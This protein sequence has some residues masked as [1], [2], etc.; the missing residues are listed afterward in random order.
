MRITEGMK[1]EEQLLA[2]LGKLEGKWASTRKRR[3][4]VNAC[5]YS[6]AFP[7]GWKLLIGLQRKNQNL[8]LYCRRFIRFGFFAGIIECRLFSTIIGSSNGVFC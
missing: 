2:V 4:I 7:D 8:R 3:K 1:T 5:D 6:G